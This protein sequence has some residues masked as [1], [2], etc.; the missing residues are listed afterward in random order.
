MS[1]TSDFLGLDSSSRVDFVKQLLGHCT[2]Q[3]QLAIMEALSTYLCRD[4][5]TILPPEVVFKILC[6]LDYREVLQHCCMVRPRLRAVTE[7]L[8]NIIE[9][10]DANCS[11]YQPPLLLKRHCFLVA[12]GHSYYMQFPNI[13]HCF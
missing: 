4:F 11:N 9:V 5:L 12:G 1:I 10:C 6:L 8:I 13:V 2:H 7:C 3:E